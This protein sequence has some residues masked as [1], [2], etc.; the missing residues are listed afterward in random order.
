MPMLCFHIGSPCNFD[1]MG[2]TSIV[3]SFSMTVKMVYSRPA[4]VM[5]LTKPWRAGPSGVGRVGLPPLSPKT[6]L[7]I[8]SHNISRRPQTVKG[9]SSFA[10]YIAAA[11]GG[12]P[13]G[14]KIPLKKIK[15]KRENTKEGLDTGGGML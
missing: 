8:L 1:A 4:A 11:C 5:V 14:A 10:S 12:V 3:I 15:Q 9:E 7:S 2:A 6:S 13:R